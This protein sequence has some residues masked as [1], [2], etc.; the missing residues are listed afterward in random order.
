MPFVQLKNTRL[1]YFR[2]GHGP[3]VVLL[4]HGFQ[5]SARIWHWL[6][7]LLPE[8]RYTTIALNNRGAG[9]S[10]APPRE[11]DYGVEVFAADAHEA[12]EQLQ[13]G[14]FTL[15]GH[16]L[17][18]AT[19]SVYAVRWPEQLKGLV[20]L[21]PADPDGREMPAAA[22]DAFID[23]R[24]QARREQ[25]AKGG[26][27]DGITSNAAAS[28]LEAP[29]RALLADMDAAPEQRLR[30]SLRSMFNVRCGAQLHALTLPSLLIGGD[31]DE[32]ISVPGMLG[33]WAKLPPGAGLHFW[34]GIGHSPNMQCP[35]E[36]AAVL[37]HFI[38]VTIPA[39]AGGAG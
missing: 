28:E 24:M 23:A 20:L 37:R 17:G 25:R 10:D 30:G 21:D 15:V 3:E 9:G 6:Q 36:L 12:A 29:M 35:A 5:A 19:A 38:E 22:L 4:I 32:L 1:E 14:R 16:S 34:H 39:R 13:L 11:E 33:T 31:A 26:G 7:H 2:H 18:G 8:D 27:G